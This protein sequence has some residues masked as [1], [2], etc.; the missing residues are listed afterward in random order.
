LFL[1][2]FNTAEEAM[3]WKLLTYTVYVVLSVVL[4]YSVARSLFRNGRVFLVVV[5]DGDKELAGSVNHLLVVGFY[6]V[7]LGFVSFM[8]RTA[9]AVPTATGAVELLSRKMGLVLLVLGAMHFG[10]LYVLSRMRRR[11][12][13]APDR[14]AAPS[15]F[16]RG[17]PPFG[18]AGTA[19]PP[20]A[21]AQ[22]PPD[23]RSAPGQRA[24]Q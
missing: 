4:T 16:V 22:A 1:N 6:L 13:P 19:Y 21:P 11:H 24:G 5:F 2:T 8:L 18:A 15:T 3:D 20:Q 23:A 9:D 12:L 14:P 17:T 10:N 7:N